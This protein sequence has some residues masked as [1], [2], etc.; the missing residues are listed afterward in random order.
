MPSP[1]ILSFQTQGTY[2]SLHTLAMAYGE[3]INSAIKADTLHPGMYADYGVALALMGHRGTSCRML[4]SEIRAF[5]ESRAMVRRIK[6]HLLPDMLDDTLCGI[7][8]TANMEQ[9]YAWAYD[10]LTALQTLPH[11]AQV[12][13]S[14]DT[15]WLSQQTPVDSV[16]R[17]MKLTANQKREL[18]IQEQQAAEAAK[19]ARLDSIEAAKKAQIIAREQAKADRAAERERQK[20]EQAAERER[21]KQEQIAARERQK[22]EQAAERERRKLEQQSAKNKQDNQEGGEE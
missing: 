12:I 10:S 19:K 15:V 11:W 14:T 2:G 9:L 13:D 21:R 18:L 7:R 6:Q 8:D 5:P 17:E 20:Q 22:Q 16:V 3:A 1:E 4:N